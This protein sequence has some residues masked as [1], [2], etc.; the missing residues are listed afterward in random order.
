[1]IRIVNP[2]LSQGSQGPDVAQVHRALAELGVAIA[3]TEIAKRLYGPSTVEAICELQSEFG[4]ATTCIVDLATQRKINERLTRRGSQER[5]VQGTVRLATGAPTSGR[6]RVRVLLTGRGDSDVPLATAK[7]D[8][9]GFFEIKYALSPEAQKRARVDLRVEV[10]ADGSDKPLSTRP[11]ARSILTNAAGLEVIDFILLEPSRQ[12]A[13]EFDQIHGD[14]QEALGEPTLLNKM[15]GGQLHLLAEQA[16]HPVSNVSA[17]AAARRLA[18]Q[19]ENKLP[20][21]LF[22]AL[23]RGG[24][25]SDLPGILAASPESRHAAVVAAVQNKIVPVAPANGRPLIAALNDLPRHVASFA[26][27]APRPGV[28]SV[29]DLVKTVL[30]DAES[31]DLLAK[32]VAA[33]STDE[34]WSSIADHPNSQPLRLAVDQ[35]SLINSH[36]PLFTALRDLRLKTTAALANIPIRQWDQLIAQSGTPDDTPG[37][38]PEEKTA[39]YKKAIFV[40]LGAA[41]PG[42]FLA[43]ELEDAGEEAPVVEFLRSQTAFDPNTTHLEAFLKKQPN[44]V[45][46]EGAKDAKEKIKTY[47]RL[48]KLTGN[49]ADAIAIKPHASSAQEIAAMGKKAFAAKVPALGEARAHEIVAR[50]E[51]VCTAA[52]ALWLEYAPKMNRTAMK[53]LPSL[54]NGA[55]AKKAVGDDEAPGPIPDWETLFGSFDLCSC[56]QCN[57]VHGPAAY[58]VDLLQFLEARGVR[59]L[60]M[61]RRPDLAEIELSCENTNTVL[62]YVDL[63]NEILED[64][65]APPAP[66]VAQALAGVQL[67]D[68]E[69][70]QVTTRL[71]NSFAP[72]LEAGASVEVMEDD[73]RWRVVDE[74]FAYSVEKDGTAFK[75]VTRSRQTTGSTETRKAYP[76]YRNAAAYTTLSEAFFPWSLPFD[77]NATEAAVF[78]EHLGTS[79]GELIAALRAPAPHIEPEPLV[80]RR[81]ALERL[82]MTEQERRIVIGEI[83]TAKT[84]FWGARP[85]DTVQDILDGSG[86]KFAELDL[87]VATRFVNPD[88]SLKIEPPGTCD[89]SLLKITGLTDAALSRLYRFVRMWRKLGWKIEYVDKALRVLPSDLKDETVDGLARISELKEK[90]KLPVLELLAFWGDIDTDG[91]ESLYHRL[92]QD[93]KLP[94]AVRES[95]RLPLDGSERLLDQAA[96]LQGVL[97]LSAPDLVKS[98]PIDGRLTLA[99]L[100]LLFRQA[101][102]MEA[103]RLSPEDLASA[104]ALTEIADPFQSPET[105]ARFV[106]IANAVT[107][108]GIR[109]DE[110]DYLLRHQLEASAAFV[111]SDESLAATLT[112]LRAS[113]QQINASATNQEGLGAPRP[114]INEADD[115][116]LKAEAERLAEEKTRARED[117]VRDRIKEAL[118]VPEGLV[119]D[120]LDQTAMNSLLE[121]AEIG[122]TKQAAKETSKPIERKNNADKQFVLVQKLLKIARIV[123]WLA[124]PGLQWKR[125]IGT[126][127]WVDLLKLPE[128]KVDSSPLSFETWY[129]LI[130][131]VWLRRYL[132][133]TDGALEAVLDAENA[134]T[135]T[136]GKRAFADALS[137][138]LGWDPQDVETLIG[139]ENSGDNGLLNVNP[140]TDYRTPELLIRLNRAIRAL[141]T[142][143]VSAAEADKWCGAAISSQDAKSIRS[144]A[145]ARHDEQS[146]PKVAKPL[147]DVSRNAQRPALVAYLL[148]RPESWR[149]VR[150]ASGTVDESDL[151]AHFLIDVEMDA[152]Q[153]T[154][155][156]KNAT[157]S[158]QLFGQRCLLGLERTD[159]QVDDE[160][161]LQWRWMKNFRVWEANRKVWLYPE[162]WIEPELRNNKTP[163]FKDLEAELLQGEI[164]DAAAEQAVLHYLEKLDQVGRL[165]ICGSYQDDEAKRL[166]VFGRTFN[167]PRIYF[168]RCANV[169]DGTPQRFSNWT[170]WTKVELDIE[171]D[172][173]IPVARGR[174]LAVLWPIISL[175]QDGKPVTMPDPGVALEAG[176]LYWEIQMAWSEYQADGR[177]G[178]K[179][180]S[181]PVTLRAYQD[182]D[183]VLFGKKVEPPSANPLK[184]RLVNDNAGD[185]GNPKPLPE[186]E[187]PEDQPPETGSSGTG[188][189][190]PSRVLIDQSL[191]SFKGLVAGDSIFVG[192]YLSLAYSATAQDREVAAPFGVFHLTGCRNIVA[193][194]PGSVSP[195]TLP[196]APSGTRFQHMWFD[197]TASGLRFLDGSLPAFQIRDGLVA[198][199]SGNIPHALFGGLPSIAMMKAAKRDIEVFRTTP[200]PFRILP[201]HQD[202]QFRGDRPFFFMDHE[203]TLM[204]TSTGSTADVVRPDLNGWTNG[205]IGM[206]WT[207][208]YF[209]GGPQPLPEGSE[210]Q[211]APEPLVLL[212]RGPDGRRGVVRVVPPDVAPNVPRNT[213]LPIFRTTRRYHF[214]AFQHPFTC[215]LME[216][217]DRKR[218]RG[219]FELPTQEMTKPFFGDYNPIPERVGDPPIDEIDF[220]SGSSY[221][222]YN[223]ELFFHV[224]LLIAD[225]LTKNQRFE[226]AQRWYHFI[227]DPTGS[228]GGEA[229]KRYWRTLPFH[230]RLVEGPGGYEEQAILNIEKALVRGLPS[231]LA[232]A[233]D[234]WRTNPFNPH[235]IARLRTTAYQK[236][237]VMKYIDNL[238]SWGDQLFRRE[239]IESLNEATQLYVLAAEILGKRPEV[240]SRKEV[241]H[242]ETFASL[243]S[244]SRLGPLSNAEQLVPDAGPPGGDKLSEDPDLPV[245]PSLY[246]CVPENDKLLGYWDTVADRLFKLRHCM[247]IEGRVR[248]LPLFEPPIDPALLVR[249]QAAGVSIAD[250]L[251]DLADRPSNYRFMVMLQ[252]ANEFTGETRNLAGVL[253]SAIEKRDGE[254]LALLRSSHELR[255]LSAARDIRVRQIEEAT[256]NIE[257]LEVGRKLAETRQRFY[258]ERS[259]ALTSATEDE[260]QEFLDDSILTQRS[261]LALRGLSAILFKIGGAKFGSPTTAGIETGANWWAFG[262]TAAASAGDSLANELSLRSQA[263]GRTAGYERRRDDWK[264]QEELATKEL[265]QIDKQ[266]EAARVRLAVATRELANHDVQ[267]E[268]SREADR[269]MR[270]KFSN[271]D[272]FGWLVGQISG[273]YFQSYQLAFDLARRAQRCMEFELGEPTGTETAIR[274]GYW[275]SLK[276][277]LTAADHLAHDLK[278]LELAHLEKCQRE[279]EITKHVS[280]LALDPNKLIDLKKDG[281]CSDIRIPEYLFDLDAPGHFL[282]RIKTVSISIPCVT[283]PYTGVHCRVQLT[284]NEIRFDKTVAADYARDLGTDDKRFI[285]DRRVIQDMVTSSGQNDS[286]LFEA[287]LH[288]ERYLPFEGAGVVSTWSLE[289]PADFRPFDYNSISDVIFHIRYTARYGGDPLR[290]KAA[291]ATKKIIEDGP[292]LRLVSLRHEFPSEWQRLIT[293]PGTSSV[294]LNVSQERFPFFVQG[295]TINISKAEATARVKPNGPALQFTVSAGASSSGQTTGPPGPWTVAGTSTRDLEDLFLVFQ[296]TARADDRPS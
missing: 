126:G 229:P 37:S 228:S 219:L 54:D 159:I 156:I 79:R 26:N 191:I 207:A 217:F 32:Y 51:H 11:A 96:T 220:R 141:K 28:A 195:R 286:G 100:S 273:L 155:R 21:E 216:A 127:S 87:I 66:F 231:D 104:K 84:E 163:F 295:K 271:A 124:L 171:G 144:A 172:H 272:L 250:V 91:P 57:S 98:I 192:A 41:F 94:K 86:L 15:N 53:A 247:D 264:L 262:L 183:N 202:Q 108:S 25:P 6:L 267:V 67:E 44:A 296:Y 249:A 12:P 242:I 222:V 83:A 8:A 16:L 294:T 266:L 122:V 93:E 7:P 89:T 121:I 135:A 246:F 99:N 72:P 103:L 185:G 139:G 275:D 35:A 58:F 75:A 205:E 194:S 176:D 213:A 245:A 4:L 105:T 158:I 208:D 257:A 285:V 198:D 31:S 181:G 92:F 230:Q 45:I 146:W 38:T 34:F 251:N 187:D 113:L 118:A 174:E 81:L 3:P 278:R 259:E 214:S 132:G 40:R 149:P 76:Q 263:L 111:P 22:Y 203:H 50:A 232:A 236:T 288:D 101:R 186:I 189:K 140:S 197:N 161:W 30:T 61:A 209:G 265:V 95:F 60:L 42:P 128:S 167:T 137:Q 211:V 133:A 221:E 178:A 248:Q 24:L 39:N 224:P 10:L 1:M 235:A 73:V 2:R 112:A 269:F 46:P 233:V 254:A 153:L 78:L 70:P 150:P 36:P 115:Q 74:Q 226:E 253:L 43:T 19:I 157:G 204:V 130:Q 64:Q 129:R 244:N 134:V 151:F 114:A 18:A 212:R 200:S 77:L 65:V 164:T 147:H 274:F 238:V 180:I 169:V 243:T 48:R 290:D 199:F 125:L 223:W 47:Q 143:G 227:F 201:P 152:C 258:A 252:K 119:K 33:P 268:N 279:Y 49:S 9:D 80:R 107:G 85:A 182:N 82:G 20:E 90:L 117:A 68:F 13:S 215:K 260:S 110:L 17:L 138:W 291:E 168:Y 165:E 289:L 276:K 188:G 190:R 154:S 292:L 184:F 131:F 239:T 145:M 234:Y 210:S 177:W 173:L 261:T 5:V 170:P 240:I 142:V 62:P 206:V 281:K 148:A 69:G 52:S 88:S 241:R 136:A 175:K 256:A 225:R 55:I 160:K 284:A 283:G 63:A 97:H 179:A 56:E 59:N 287:N 193:T 109:W 293:S 102:L 23:I 116:R 123:N 27:V 120:L 277:G 162:N 29:H 255:L 71:K 196:L 106:T 237:V 166:H 270:D 280:M 218:L 14:L 282:R